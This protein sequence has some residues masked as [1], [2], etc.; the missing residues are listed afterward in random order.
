MWLSLCHESIL[1]CPSLLIECKFLQGHSVVIYN[2]RYTE[3]L[4]DKFLFS[5]PLFP[6][7]PPFFFF[8]PNCALHVALTLGDCIEVELIFFNMS[9][10]V[11]CKWNHIFNSHITWNIY[12]RTL[13]QCS[14]PMVCRQPVI[15]EHSVISVEISVECSSVWTVSLTFNQQCF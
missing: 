3:E 1:P 2:T 12:P 11:D 5:F 14:Q 13:D 8:C 4:F 6:P 15:C 10:L 7:P 9:K